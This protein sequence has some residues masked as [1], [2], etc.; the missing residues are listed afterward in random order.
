MR[1]WRFSSCIPT[2]I[3]MRMGARSSSSLLRFA[4]LCAALLP[5]VRVMS[6]NGL[7]GGVV[8]ADITLPVAVQGAP[9]NQLPSPWTS[10]DIGAVGLAGSASYSNG[11]FTIKGAGADIWETQD[12]FHFMH[13]TVTGDIDVVARVTSIQNTHQ[14]AK[15]GV[16]LRGS[17]AT[18]S[19]HVIMSYMPGG[20]LEFMT[21]SSA[22]ATTPFPTQ[23]SGASLPIWLRLTRTG[24]QVTG[25]W[26]NSGTSW[27][28]IGTASPALPATIYAGLPVLSHDTELL[29]TAT[30][31]NVAV[32]VPSTT[33]PPPTI[34]ITAPVRGATFT[35]PSSIT[36]AASASDS[37]GTVSSVQFFAN[38]VSLGTDT[39][40]PYSVSWNQPPP[41]AY[42]ITA[43]ATDSGGAQGQA[44]P[45]N[46]TV[47]AA[48]TQL[49][50]PWVSI[51]VGNVGAAGSASASAGT[52]TIKGAGED[53]WGT[54][55]AFA[56]VHQGSLAIFRSSR[57]SRPCRTR[58]RM[59]KPG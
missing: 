26:S 11:V 40:S 31:D 30:F 24:S 52:F 20:Q 27:I 59:P 57:A 5:L 4:T 38:G 25:Y 34:S 22:G 8:S 42:T 37:N 18:N 9:G 51:D 28:Q 23:V 12:S 7:A 19:P 15:A 3:L 47:N 6:E 56:F 53:I 33:N 1:S 16:M 55:D 36:V 41:G 54:A 43:V 32:V 21:R 14:F 45:V 39:T 35:A 17:L 29:N 50:A 58:T 48:S 49:P 2:G 10:Q 13:R 46:I 44:T